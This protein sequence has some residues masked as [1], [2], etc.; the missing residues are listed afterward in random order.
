MKYTPHDYQVYATE[1]IKAKPACAV[2]LDC[3]LGKTVITLTAIH[4][5]MRDTFDV[6]K[7]LVI[8]PLRVAKPYGLQRYRSG[9]ICKTYPAALR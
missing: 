7:V 5:L 8:A 3:G 1:Y 2:F 6:R 9:S 4:D